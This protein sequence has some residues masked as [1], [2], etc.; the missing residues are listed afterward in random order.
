LKTLAQ[1]LDVG[2]PIDTP[3]LPS[4]SSPV[5]ATAFQMACGKSGLKGIQFLIERGANVGHWD[6]RGRTAL[7]WLF[8]QGLDEDDDSDRCFERFGCLGRDE[9]VAA[10]AQYL[11]DMM[12]R[13]AV[14]AIDTDGHTA[15]ESVLAT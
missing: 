2:Y 6:N 12:E 3:T 11:I 1:P 8:K 15:Y 14:F 5:G 4:Q 7:H 9:D 10:M 13:D